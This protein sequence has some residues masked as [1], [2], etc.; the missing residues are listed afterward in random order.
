MDK[1]AGRRKSLVR[2][3][4]I[5]LVFALIA[6]LAALGLFGES[7]EYSPPMDPAAF[8]ALSYEKQQ[9]W[10]RDHSRRITGLSELRSRV[11]HARFWTQEYPAAA[12]S[13]FVLVFLSCAAI[14]VWERRDAL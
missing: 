3:V 5:S 10:L 6:P 4:V 1:Y 12:L 8:Y 2:I 7:V 11:K 14:V 13:V 9:E